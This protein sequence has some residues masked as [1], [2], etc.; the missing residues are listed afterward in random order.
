MTRRR[1]PTTWRKRWRSV[2][3]RWL[4]L[5]VPAALVLFAAYAVAFLID[6]PL[7]RYT[8][9]NMNRALKGYTVHVTALRFHPLGF[10]L[11]L[12]D[13]VVVQ[14]AH[15]D[16][17]VARI[18]LLKASVHWRALLHGR[19]VGDIL[20]K[21]PTVHVNLTQA[22]KELA[23]PTP[24]KE[25][26]WQEALEAIYPLKLN[27]F[28]VTNGDLTYVDGPFKPLRVRSL[29]IV[30]TNIR[31]VRSP[32]RTYPS[33]FHVDG[34][35]FESGRLSA[36]GH[37][38]FLAEPNPT[39]RADLKLAGIELDYLKPITNRY[40]VSVDKGILSAEGMIESGKDTTRVELAR[41]AILDVRVDYLHAATTAVA[42]QTQRAQAAQAARKVNNAPG[43]LLSIKELRVRKSTFGFVSKA[44]TPAY[45][46][47]L[48][49]TDGTMTNLSN[50]ETQGPAVVKL[51]GRF[52][53]TGT[54]TADATFRAEKSG[55][56]FQVAVKIDDVDMPGMNDLLRAYGN[57]DVTA[58]RFFFYSELN[59]KDGALS[60]YVKPF[61]KDMVVYDK[62]QDKEKPLVRKVYERV[63]GGVAKVLENR[64]HEQVATRVEI[65]GRIDNPQVSVVDVIVRL[66]QNAFFKAILPG[67]D[68]ETRRL[69]SAKKAP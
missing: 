54:A 35:V 33:E 37:A 43:V 20:I 30:A 25:R 64:P 45:R 29:N 6:E 18:P 40:N 3:R 46:V 66:V 10:S 11:T 4:F 53:G 58:G 24:V 62:T 7:R 49:D 69:S 17:A 57:F 50:H 34:A 21:R 1:G 2:P 38:D 56:A 60:G 63:V 48:A 41:V 8:E 52:M 31:N 44:T 9:A 39:F 65:S 42:E 28:R 5:G 47:F 14:D 15:P 16:P 22:K 32:D 59:A 51:K 26:G 27:Q 55:P 19:V 12:K 67:L 68:Q 23:D 13:T 61:F 36:D